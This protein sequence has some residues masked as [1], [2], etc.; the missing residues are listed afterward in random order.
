VGRRRTTKK[1]STLGGTTW[2]TCVHELAE[3][4]FPK[5]QKLVQRAES[6]LKK[7]NP[8]VKPCWI[9]FAGSTRIQKK[10]RNGDVLI[11]ATARNSNG[12]PYE[13]EPPSSLLKKQ[14]A[15]RWTRFYYDSNLSAPLKTISWN[16]FQRLLKSAGVRTHVGKNSTRAI[17]VSE[18]LELQ[19]IWP[20]IKR[21]T[22]R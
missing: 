11:A 17:S 10:A 19:R 4:A 3:D 14:D 21:R 7:L 8:K 1:V 16:K 6:E 9:R 5:E 20:R 13:V 12:V 15:G 22:T 2:I 18:A